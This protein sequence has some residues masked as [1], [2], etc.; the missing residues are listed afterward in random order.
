MGRSRPFGVSELAMDVGR[1]FHVTS[2]L[3]AHPY[4]LTRQALTRRVPRRWWPSNSIASTPAR[5]PPFNQRFRSDGHASIPMHRLLPF[6]LLA[7]FCPPAPSNA[8]DAAPAA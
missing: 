3:H 1:V 4:T 2:P 5:V 7:L 6:P 8:R